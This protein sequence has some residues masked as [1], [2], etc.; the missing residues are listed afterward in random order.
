MLFRSWNTLI[1]F[2]MLFVVAGS[3]D[4]TGVTRRMA[5]GF[6]ASFG[7]HPTVLISVVLGISA[8]CSAFVENIIFVAAFLPVVVNLEEAPYLW[9]LLHGACLGGNITIVGSTA[10]LAALSMLEKRYWTRVNFFV[11]LRTGIVVGVLSC[12]VAWACLTVMAPHMP[13]KAERL[14]DAGRAAIAME[15]AVAENVVAHQGAVN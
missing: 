1:F 14:R 8:I 15:E 9:A 4:H 3:L 6:A 12:L 7:D 2:M 5:E 11:W 10:N 13:T